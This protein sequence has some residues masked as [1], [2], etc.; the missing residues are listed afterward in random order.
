VTL[1]PQS[2]HS[3]FMPAVDVSSRTA[4]N[5]PH[6]GQ[7]VLTAER[8]VAG[9]LIVLVGYLPILGSSPSSTKEN[10]RRLS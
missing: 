8:T 1:S 4:N 9:C 2:A 6:V 5:S 10:H 3:P 7:V